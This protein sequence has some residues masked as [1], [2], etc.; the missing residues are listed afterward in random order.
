MRDSFLVILPLIAFSCGMRSA[1]TK[2]CAK[3]AVSTP[4]PAPSDVSSFCAADLLAAA[5]CAAVLWA[6]AAAALE[7]AALEVEELTEVV[8]I[9]TFDQHVIDR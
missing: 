7:V 4:E 1:S 6:A 8:A 5:T 2:F 9:K 3:E